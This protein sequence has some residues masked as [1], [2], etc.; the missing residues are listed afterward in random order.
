MTT[1]MTTHAHCQLTRSDSPPNAMGAAATPIVVVPSTSPLA[2]A[3]LRNGIHAWTI[4]PAAGKNGAVSTPIANRT[5]SMA[6]NAS[7]NSAR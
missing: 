3:R 1:P 5:S 6:P 7:P 2:Q 4:R